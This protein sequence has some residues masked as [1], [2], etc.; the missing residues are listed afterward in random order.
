ML[1]HLQARAGGAAQGRTADARACGISCGATTQRLAILTDIVKTA[2]S[3]L[4]PRKVIEAIMAKVQQLIPSEAW[5]MLMVDEERQELTFELAL[6]EKGKDVSSFRVKIGEG[7]AGWVAQT[8]KPTIVNDTS[9]DPRFARRFD[10]ETQF[11][12]RSILCAPL[13]SR[14]RTIGVVQVINRLGGQFTQAD[15]ELLL[16]LVEPCAIAIENA[17]LFQRTEQ[18]TIT[19]DL[20]KLFNS[21]YLNLYIGREIKRC[22]RHGIPLSVIFL[23]LD[24]FKSVN[25]QYG[26]LAGSRTLTE[27]G[28]HPGRGGARVRHPGPLRRRRVR[29]GA[30]RDARRRVRW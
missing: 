12:T 2:N 18:L 11:R 20:T 24:G 6:G 9:K 14:G 3:I 22:K 28:A 17:I 16:T 23:D 21:R 25:D 26:H 4:E 5:S 7:I 13:I 8:G 1:A 30:P 19:D 10:T 15:L 27:V 29:G